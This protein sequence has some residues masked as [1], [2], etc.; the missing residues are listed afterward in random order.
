M[1]EDKAAVTG[2]ACPRQ[3]RST[4]WQVRGNCYP[5]ETGRRYLARW[6]NR[7]IFS[8]TGMWKGVQLIISIGSIRQ[9]RMTEGV[10]KSRLKSKTRAQQGSPRAD[11][12]RQQTGWYDPGFTSVQR[13]R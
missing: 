10:A 9:A 5:I 3:R 13:M 4:W 12:L 1:T 7:V 8:L 11:S 2:L 6:L